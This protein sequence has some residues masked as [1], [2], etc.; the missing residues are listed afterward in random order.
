MATTATIT[1]KHPGTG[2]QFLALSRSFCKK[3]LGIINLRTGG[4]F[5]DAQ[6]DGAS[7]ARIQKGVQVVMQDFYER[8][9]TDH[10][11]QSA[12][13]AAS[14]AVQQRGQQTTIDSSF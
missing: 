2:A 14:F 11:A 5:T 8:S 3:H 12:G 7:A 10:D 13:N 6:V 9:T 4:S 1:L